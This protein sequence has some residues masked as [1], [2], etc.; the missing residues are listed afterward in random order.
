MSSIGS[1]NAPHSRLVAPDVTRA[2]AMVG[3]IT[4]NYIGYLMLRGGTRGGSALADLFDPWIGPLATRFA[5][6]FVVV[7]GIGATLLA[8]SASP[9]RIPHLVMRWRLASRGLVLLVGGLAFDL[10]WRGTILTYYGAL[11]I[12]AAIIITLP[13]VAIIVIG[14]ATAIGGWGLDWWIA[15]RAAAGN[16]MTWITDPESWSPF[17]VFL[18]VTVNGTH[19]LLPWTAFFCAGILIGRSLDARTWTSRW[20]TRVMAGAVIIWVIASVMQRI[21]DDPSTTSRLWSTEP[22]ERGLLYTASALATAIIAFGLIDI[23]SNRWSDTAGI[24]LLREVGQVSLTVYIAH[25]LLFN[26]IVD[27]LGIVEPGAVTT[28]IGFALVIAVVTAAAAVVWARHFGRGPVEW[29]YRRI[30]V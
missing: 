16:D 24:G 2:A 21:L 26:L 8:R 4:M 29:L 11:F 20:R 18:D 13:G 7:A 12:L 9:E 14:L 22:N 19:P 23:A 15:E 6:T 3:V 30:T 1:D 28:S 25:A 5:A 27:W 10:I 17:G